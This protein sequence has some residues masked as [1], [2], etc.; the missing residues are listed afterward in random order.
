MIEK[1][2]KMSDF[3]Q[4]DFI[5]SVSMDESELPETV[6]DKIIVSL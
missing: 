3:F 1:L 2:D 5:L 4:V 6:K